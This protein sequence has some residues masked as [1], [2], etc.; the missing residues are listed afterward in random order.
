M[1]T[2]L[3]A[4]RERASGP[5][6]PRTPSPPWSLCHRREASMW[7][8]CTGRARCS[9]S[10]W[11][12]WL[13]QPGLLKYPGGRGHSDAQIRDRQRVVGAIEGTGIQRDHGVDLRPRS[14]VTVSDRQGTGASNT[15]GTRRR[16]TD[17]TD[18]GQREVLRLVG[19]SQGG[20][21]ALQ[22][23][24]EYLTIG[25][26][27]FLLVHLSGRGLSGGITICACCRCSRRRGRRE[28]PIR[29]HQHI[30]VAIEVAGSN[31]MMSFFCGPASAS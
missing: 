31:V 26:G 18:S 5:P 9:S 22:G 8:N 20:L 6:R 1:I 13:Q 2:R 29:D 15:A 21:K 14:I 11:R 28:V 12:P 10:Y 3:R 25:K 27:E 30:G 24:M 19:K 16:P 7:Q 17:S 23:G 4:V